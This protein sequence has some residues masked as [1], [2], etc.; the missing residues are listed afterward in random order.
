MN[1]PGVPPNARDNSKGKKNKKSKSPGKSSKSPGPKNL[2]HN[3][4][5]S[6]LNRK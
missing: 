3:P 6:P 1:S 4:T 2:I 5:H